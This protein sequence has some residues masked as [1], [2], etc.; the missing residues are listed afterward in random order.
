MTQ[1]SNVSFDAPLTGSVL[2]PGE[3]TP[4]SLAILG[5]RRCS[6]V[7]RSHKS[8]AVHRSN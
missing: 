7:V 2:K 4:V 5:S 1:V 8:Y 6:G 3:E